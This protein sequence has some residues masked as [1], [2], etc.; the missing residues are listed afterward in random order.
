MLDG[1]VGGLAGARPGRG[2]LHDRAQSRAVLDV[3]QVVAVVAGLVEVR[4]REPDID[5]GGVLVGRRRSSRSERSSPD[6]RI[7]TASAAAE[8]GGGVRA[9]WRLEDSHLEVWVE[10][11]GPGLANTTNLFVPFFTT[12]PGGSGIGLALCR[13]IAEAHNGSVTL[14]NRENARGC[15]ARLRLPVGG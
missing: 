5:A 11:D 10:D 14:E 6:L 9:G 4:E 13:Q 15:E 7:L 8:A 2:A 3:D 12:K 1:E